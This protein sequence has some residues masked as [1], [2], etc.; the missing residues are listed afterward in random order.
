MA[1]PSPAP[2]RRTDF[3]A[4]LSDPDLLQLLLV[5]CPDAVIVTSPGDR[6]ALYTGASEALF[7]FA[8]IEVLGRRIG[9]L[10]P[11]R[12][13]RRQLLRTLAT[14]GFV[15]GLELSGRRKDAPPFTASVSAARVADRTGEALATVFY[16]R[17]HSAVRQIEDAL[18]RNNAQL[19]SLV[20]RL[21]HLARHDPL[22]RLLNRAAA[23]EA[24]EN[25]L[26]AFP[27]GEA[28]LGIAIFDLDRFKAVNDSYGHLAGDAVLE[29]FGTILRQQARHGDIVARFGGEEFVAFL[30]GATLADTASFAE[31]IRQATQAS[32]VRIDETLTISVTVSAGVSS[33][34]D[35]AENLEEAVR[36][37]DERLYDAKRN[38]RN[39]VV[40]D[41][42]HHR[43]AA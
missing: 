22:T 43:S 15:S 25:I 31:R 38:G 8:P 5:A 9:F 23:F 40:A 6:I 21:D 42:S 33:I 36:L 39:R 28:R 13:A 20:A 34:P 1:R 2:A 3:L 26:L 4:V 41:D 27:V 24:A 12:E 35:S 14:H 17:D 16:I 11:G 19:T 10:F 30:P 32:P 29:K 18:R 37:A 7:G